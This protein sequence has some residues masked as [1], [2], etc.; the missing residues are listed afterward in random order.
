MTGLQ[1]LRNSPV[2][3]RM[4]ARPQL[5]IVIDRRP[6][7]GKSICHWLATNT[8]LSSWR[9]STVPLARI[10]SVGHLR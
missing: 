10:F 6:V 4:E 1:E 9:A 2:Y 8:I 5:L 7:I 3:A